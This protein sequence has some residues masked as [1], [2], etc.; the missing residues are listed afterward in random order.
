MEG[1]PKV[2]E[3]DSRGRVT[4]GK[5]AEHD[6]YLVTV[7]PGGTIVLHPAVVIPRV[8]GERVVPAFDLGDDPFEGRNHV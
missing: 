7:E 1:K 2:L 8:G 3:V 6:L 5:L 4:L